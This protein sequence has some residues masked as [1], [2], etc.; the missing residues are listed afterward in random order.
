MTIT[1]Q[2]IKA[3]EKFAKEHMDNLTWWHTRQVRDLAL[4]LAKKEGADAGIVEIAALLHDIGKS[5]DKNSRFMHHISG[6]RIARKLLRKNRFAQ[7]DTQEIISCIMRHMGPYNEFLKAKLK[8]SEIPL[9]S[10]PRPDTIE[11]K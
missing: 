8:T 3:V 10:C 9:S 4:A 1:K 2:Q 11:A 6:S 5:K 7:K